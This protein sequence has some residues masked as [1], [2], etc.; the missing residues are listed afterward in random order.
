MKLIR[1]MSKG[2]FDKRTFGQTLKDTVIMAG[3][4]K[5]YTNAQEGKVLQ[6]FQRLYTDVDRPKDVWDWMRGFE[7]GKIEKRRH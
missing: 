4:L 5:G 1:D 6:F 3:L 2:H 7:T